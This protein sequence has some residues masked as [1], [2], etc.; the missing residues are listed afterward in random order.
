MTNKKST[1]DYSTGDYSTGNYSTGNRSTGD[2]STGDYSTGD[3]STGN[4]STGNYSTGYYSTGNYSTGDYSTG[5]RSTGD[6]STGN[7]STGNYST[8]N[9]STG[10]YSTGDYSTGNWSISNYSSWHFC[11]IDYMWFSC[12]NKPITVEEW[13]N[14]DIP[15]WLYFHPTEWIYEK[16]MTD[17]EKKNNPTYKTTW[18]Y[19]KVY[20]YKEAFRNAFD[21]ADKDDVAK[22]LN[23]IHFDYDIFEEISGITKED[24]DK[25]LNKKEEKVK[26]KTII[27]DWIEYILTPK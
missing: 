10:D 19:L 9:R 4:R 13:R 7:Y 6:Y 3:Y 11:T 22:T 21:K 12:F 14:R 17:E 1:G 16:N 2:Y 23:I 20:K 24:F 18:W 15:N 25:K 8:G 5:N 26:E 27:L